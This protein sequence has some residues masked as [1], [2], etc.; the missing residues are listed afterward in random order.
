MLARLVAGWDAHR[1]GLRAEVLNAIG[2]GNYEHEDW[3]MQQGMPVFAYTTEEQFRVAIET[4][5]TYLLKLEEQ[6]LLREGP[7]TVRMGFS[8]PKPTL[9]ARDREW[10]EQARTDVDGLLRQVR[11]M[12]QWTVGAGKFG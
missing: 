4:A 3:D 12:S 2:L 1:S 6:R 10:M 8:K 11:A 5:E 7:W 9:G